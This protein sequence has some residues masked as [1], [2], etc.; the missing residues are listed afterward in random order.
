MTNSIHNAMW[1]WF[2]QCA[3]ITKLFFNFSGTEDS[4]TV[5]AT[6][7]DMVLEDYID[8]SQRRRYSFE[9]I[10][11]LPAIFSANDTGN[12]MMMEDVETIVAWV[13]QQ[14]ADGNLPQLPDGY[15]A[16]DITALDEYAGVAVAR[17]ENTAKYMIP[18]AL[19]YVKG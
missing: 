8:G 16:E 2:G 7:G 12:I 5:I 13:K 9:L 18:F 10:R 4:D 1:E 14:A 19:D 17:D 15:Q 3:Y 6:A 11:Y